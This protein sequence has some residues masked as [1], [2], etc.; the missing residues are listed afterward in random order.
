MTYRILTLDGGGSWALL[1][2]MALRA[3]AGDLPADRS[4]AVSTWRWPIPAAAS[5]SAR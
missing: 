4:S 5:C 1:Q 3:L 2:A